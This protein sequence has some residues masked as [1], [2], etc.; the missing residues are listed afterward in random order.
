M[1]VDLPGIG[2]G[3]ILDASYGFD[4]L[5]DCIHEL[6]IQ[7]GISKV[8]IFSTSYSSII[9]YEFSLR[10]TSF[11]EKLVISS[12]MASLPEAQ[13]SIMRSCINALENDDI[14]SFC[15]IFIDGVCHP[16]KHILNYDLS[17]KV[18]QKLA[19]L[20]TPVEI[21]QF[22]ENTNR[23]LQY[24]IAAM[25]TSIELSPLIFTG[26]YDSFTPPDLCRKIGKL[27][28]HSH[29]G[30]ID[31]YDHLFHIG[32]RQTIIQSILPFFREGRLPH[33]ADKDLTS[34]Q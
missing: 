15:R 2:E 5:A 20:L 18:I 10:Y 6:L 9:A 34:A 25:E 30:M 1:V 8:H 13:R 32:N 27:Y 16:G 23:V 4:F 22:I 11:V 14:E 29:F 7:L 26:A 3:R 31:D 17:R 12:S 33:F 19:Y 21:A 28:T 24:K